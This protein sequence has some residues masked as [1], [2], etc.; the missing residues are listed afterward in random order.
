MDFCCMEMLWIIQG[1]SWARSLEH[2]CLWFTNHLSWGTLQQ[3]DR[4]AAPVLPW[5][6]IRPTGTNSYNRM[7]TRI[8]RTRITRGNDPKE[9]GAF[10]SAIG[11]DQD[12]SCNCDTWCL[13]VTAATAVFPG[14][15]LHKLYVL[16][17][18]VD[19]IAGLLRCPTRATCSKEFSKLCK[20]AP[21][22]KWLLTDLRPNW[23]IQ[24]FLPRHPK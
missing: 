16:P 7:Q 22:N 9:V 20:S 21:S 23:L 8:M 15:L 17:S 11:P 24:P 6:N 3:K 19:E 13:H 12:H 1:K 18:T 5:L 4:C 14:M 2:N 10:S